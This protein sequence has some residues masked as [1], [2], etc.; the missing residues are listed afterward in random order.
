MAGNHLIP[1]KLISTSMVG[2]YPQPPWLVDHEKLRAVGAPRVREPGI[3]RVADAEREQA[4]D[5]AIRLAVSDMEAAGIDIVTDGEIRRESY[6]NQFATALEGVTQVNPHIL[7]PRPGLHIKVPRV[8]G[9]VRRTGDVHVRD[10]KFLRDQTKH[11]IKI[12][13]PGPFTMGLQAKN[14]YYDDDEEMA[15]DFAQAVNEEALALEAAGADIIQLDEPWL[16]VDLDRANAYGVRVI[17]RALRGLRAA[18]AV[19]LCFG[20]GKAPGGKPTHYSFLEQLGGSVVQQISFEAAQIQLDLGVLRSLTGK[21]IMLGSLDLSTSEVET[22]DDVAA[23]IRRGLEYV[24]PEYLMPAPDCG[25]KFLSRDVA[26]GKLQ[27]L[28]R[29][30]TL[31]R[32]ELQ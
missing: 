2:S 4:Q 13:L 19:H 23:R 9:P 7:E 5:D 6:S 1:D 15:M 30:A 31:V 27:A 10:A 8:V 22:I 11:P 20:Y 26:L 18:T 12:T 14:E 21:T 28:S 25:M 16:R 17:D 32:G 3:W 29:A 24:Q